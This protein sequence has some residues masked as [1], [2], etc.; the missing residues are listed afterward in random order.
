MIQ[1]PF[2]LTMI[3]I[4]L[5]WILVRLSVYFKTKVF[6]WKREAQLLLVYICLVVVVRLT[7]FPFEKV[8]G[9]IQPLLFDPGSVFP[10]N[11]N[12]TAIKYIM[13]YESQK[14]A[15]LNLFGNIFLLMPLGIIFPLV[16]K[17]LNTPLKAIA[18]GIGTSLTIEIFQL[19]F[20][21]RVTDIN[22]LILNSAGYIAGYLIY[23][24][25]RKAKKKA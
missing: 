18:V 14:E 11:V 15:L 2:P 5:L 25:I 21:Q 12:F 9:K 10:L 6:S 1:I 19:P 13:E 7:F 8:D 24:L 17:K 3:C 16:D 23:L 20:F 22:D 4:S